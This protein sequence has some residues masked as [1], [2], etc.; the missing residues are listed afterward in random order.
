MAAPG[1]LR[2]SRRRA[3][4]LCARA[5]YSDPPKYLV[6]YWLFYEFDDYHTLRR[7]LWQAHEGDWE[8]ISVAVGADGQPQFAAYSQHC[9][10]TVRTWSSVE[11]RGSTHPVAYVALGSHANYFTNQPKPTRFTE[12]L[13]SGTA[14]ATVER[15]ARLAQERIEDRTGT[16][17]ALGPAGVA[18][19]TPLTI[20]PITSSNAWTQF[21]AAGARASCSG[22]NSTA[23]VH[24]GLP[25]L[26]P[27]DAALDVDV[28][29]VALARR[30]EL[31]CRGACRDE[32]SGSRPIR[33]HPIRDAPRLE[34]LGQVGRHRSP[35]RPCRAIFVSM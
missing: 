18:G 11:K 19:T 26:R 4:R 17:H 6:R 8:S 16:A 5:G 13:K 2:P 33:R 23:V 32:R 20:I 24:L 15:I 9:S 34:P 21:P 1:R 10:G 3:T 12:C 27:G 22:W 25:G 31:S 29:P 28:N 35:A 7:R 30:V 14:S